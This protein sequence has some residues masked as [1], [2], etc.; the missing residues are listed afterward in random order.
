MMTMMMMMMM[1]SI[2]GRAEDDILGAWFMW[3]EGGFS[4]PRDL[5]EESSLVVYFHGNSQ[6]RGFGHRVGIIQ[7]LHCRRIVLLALLSISIA[8]LNLDLDLGAMTIVWLDNCYHLVHHFLHYLPCHHILVTMK[9]I[10]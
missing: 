5:P 10:F 7:S 3:P 2:P 6:D 1:T 4:R 8:I 9:F